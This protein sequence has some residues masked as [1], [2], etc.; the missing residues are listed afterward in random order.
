MAADGVE[1]GVFTSGSRTVTDTLHTP[2]PAAGAASHP[3]MRAAARGPAAADIHNPVP[4]WSHTFALNLYLI[5][6]FLIPVQLE[7]ESVKNIIGSRLPPGD[8]FLAFSVLLAPASFRILKQPLGYLPLALPLVLA[9]GSVVALV[10]QGELT[11]HSVNVKFLGSAVLLVT[12]VVTMAYAHAGFTVRIL[13][14]L[15]AGVAFWGFVG[16]IDWRVAN[17]FPWLDVDIESRFGGMVFDPNNAGALF[18]V[19]LLI[20]WRYGHRLFERQLV[21]ILMTVWFAVALGLTL[22]RGAFIG[23]AGAIVIV[24]AVDHVTAEKAMRYAVWAIGIATFLFASGFVED[25]VNDFSRRPDTV[26]SRGSFVD[27]AVDRWVDSRGL[28]M[29]LGTFRAETT[30]IVHNTGIWLVVEMS[31]PGLLFFLAMI[32][33]PFQALLR[34][35]RYD[36]ELAMAL[37][38]A[39]STMIVASVGIEALYQRSWWV[40]IGLTVM[41]LA[42]VRAK[43]RAAVLGAPAPIDPPLIDPPRIDPAR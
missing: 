43:Q 36:H 2:D 32:V 30:R 24:L 20:S 28:G 38:A 27:I 6:I 40:I 25:A 17:I 1:Y 23:T 26:E 7:I 34:L 10:L 31:L 13:R 9:Y 39:H 19:A 16:Y 42:S 37:L 35:R 8:I 15:L 33:V 18:A 22:S 21:W 29:G 3:T 5:A 4:R 41:P 12:G 14:A 11:P